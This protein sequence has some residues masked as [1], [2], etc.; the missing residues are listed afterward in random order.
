MLHAGLSKAHANMPIEGTFVLRNG[1]GANK[2]AAAFS[3]SFDDLN[4]YCVTLFAIGSLKNPELPDDAPFDTVIYASPGV[5]YS[6][7]PAGVSRRARCILS[8]A[9][10]HRTA[11]GCRTLR[12]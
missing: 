9:T 6:A 10:R 8:E 12:A 4:P 7:F 2:F 3:I 5:N 11:N 1:H